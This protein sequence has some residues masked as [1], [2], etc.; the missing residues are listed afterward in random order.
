MEVY[1]KDGARLEVDV[2][3]RPYRAFD[4]KSYVSKH[5][6]IEL[7]NTPG[8][9]PRIVTGLIKFMDKNNFIQGNIPTLAKRIGVTDKTL[10]GTINTMVKEYYIRQHGAALFQI[11]PA[12]WF[13]TNSHLAT[14]SYELFIGKNSI[15][16][17]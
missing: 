2:S 5:L 8:I 15:Q 17:V 12:L 14:A 4:K 16:E 3:E 10:R 1:T 11:N 7:F 6:L 13:N 9:S